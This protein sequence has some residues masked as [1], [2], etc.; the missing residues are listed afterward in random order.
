MSTLILPSKSPLLTRTGWGAW[1]VP[2]IV[3]ARWCQCSTCGFQGSL[4]H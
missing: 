1:L 4:F 3:C 2:L